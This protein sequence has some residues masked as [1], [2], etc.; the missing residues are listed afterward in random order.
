MQHLYRKDN[1]TKIVGTFDHV[2][3]CCEVTGWTV[4]ADGKPEPEFAGGSEMYWDDSFT[5]TN[6]EG[7]MWLVD[8]N[9]EQVLMSDCEVRDD[10][11]AEDDEDDEL[12]PSFDQIMANPDTVVIPKNRDDQCALA[13]IVALG[14][15]EAQLGAVKTFGERMPLEMQAAMLRQ[16]AQRKGF[17][18]AYSPHYVK[19]LCNNGLRVLLNGR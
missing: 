3:C 8:E 15:T 12:A 1:G 16:M 18:L 14:C 17:G 11:D 5:Q 7:V 6:P 13:T 19:W 10:D 9:G 2:P 4:G